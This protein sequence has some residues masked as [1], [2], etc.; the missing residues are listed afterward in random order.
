MSDKI[1]APTYT[2]SE[3]MTHSDTFR[4]AGKCRGLLRRVEICSHVTSRIYEVANCDFK[5]MVDYTGR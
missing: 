3:Y 1:T 2:L 4:F 5:I